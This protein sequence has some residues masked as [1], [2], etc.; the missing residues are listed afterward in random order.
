MYVVDSRQNKLLCIDK[1]FGYCSW[2]I[3]I[4]YEV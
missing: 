4:I 1:Y 2:Q 3:S